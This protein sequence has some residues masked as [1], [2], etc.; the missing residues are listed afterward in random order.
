M[1]EDKA[2]VWFMD[3]R[4]R[5][6]VDSLELKAR[7]LFEE[8]ELYECFKPGDQVAIKVHWGEM[9][10]TSYLRPNLIGVIIDEVKEHGGFP[11]VAEGTSLGFNS[12]RGTGY[13][14]TSNGAA[15]GYNLATFG[16]PVISADGWTGT[17]DIEIDLPE[18]NILKRT[19]VSKPLATADAMI[20]VSHWKGH[21]AGGFGGAIK[22]LGIGCVSKR[23]KY[24]AHAGVD[25]EEEVGVDP[26]KCPGTECP[27]SEMCQAFCYTGAIR[28]DEG[29]LHFN[30]EL[31]IFCSAACICSY[32]GG[33][34][35]SSPVGRKYDLSYQ[36]RV[37]ARF[38]DNA[39]GVVKMIDSNNLAYVNYMI[40]V[41]PSCD[42]AMAADNQIVP[43]VGVFASRD[44]VAID[45]A[46]YDK[47]VEMQGLP[48]S[49][50]EGM[51]VGVDKLREILKFDP[52]IQLKV[53]AKIGLGRREYILVTPD[54][55]EMKAFLE[56]WPWKEQAAQYLRIVAE[57][58]PLKKL[59]PADHPIW[60]SLRE[61][62]EKT[63]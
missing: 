37:E 47:M 49:Q 15:H 50:A 17:D 26:S 42:C 60:S 45:Q 61:R 20:V 24:L 59:L 41:T 7:H 27:F 1:V 28:V 36:E 33:R 34:A 31:C 14:Y 32:F 3:S 53:G 46:C 5:S 51:S 23:G 38:T 43:N 29:G 48:D 16:C 10:N 11:F 56:L 39:L 25:L 30:R 9:L 63:R 18:G 44:P 58:H 52:T 40:D 12:L 19:F 35:I 13:T 57:N 21:G 55:I 2:R 6:P 4:V 8:A 62:A 22:N 54:P